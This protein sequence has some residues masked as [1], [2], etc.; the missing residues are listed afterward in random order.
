MRSPHAADTA[1][2]LDVAHDQ[3]E[4]VVKRCTSD[5]RPVSASTARQAVL[6]SNVE[7][8]SGTLNRDGEQVIE[9]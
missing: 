3:Y 7:G 5:F 4:M 6:A 1:P 8:R 9:T 2:R